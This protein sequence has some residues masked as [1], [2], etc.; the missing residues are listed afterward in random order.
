[1]FMLYALAAG[2]VVGWLL[3][4]RLSGLGTMRI[5]WAPVALVGLLAQVVLFFGPVA[6]TVGAI[7][8]VA[9]TGSTIVV[10]AVVLRNLALPGLPLVAVGTTANLIAIL[11]N[12]GAM[13]ASPGALA[14]V[15]HGVNDGYSNS[16]ILADPA[17]WL[18]T[19][20]FAIPAP[21]PFANVLSVG[22]ILVAIGIAW[23][24]VS[25]MRAGASGN[26]PTRYPHPGT[27]GS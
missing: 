5:R 8:G 27:H 18:L 13:P 21:I 26:L 3:G 15:G 7:G 12:G 4:G 1:M 22:D 6:E 2:L 14:M 16:A 20:I 25:G 11:A 23:A 24:I 9:Y 19:D 17:V 10:L